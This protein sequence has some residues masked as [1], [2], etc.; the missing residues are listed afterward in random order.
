[1]V[2]E[3][4]QPSEG[5]LEFIRDTQ[6]AHNYLYELFLGVLNQIQTEYSNIFRRKPE[7]RMKTF[8][9][10]KKGFQKR[11]DETKD[12]KTYTAD[13]KDI[14]GLRLTIT[15]SDEYPFATEILVNNENLKMLG[16]LDITSRKNNGEPNKRGYSAYHY[17]LYS[18]LDKISEFLNYKLK[19][20]IDEDA[21][22]NFNNTLSTVRGF[23]SN[24]L[25]IQLIAELQI[26]TL[27]QDL[28]AV[29]EHPERYKSKV[30]SSSKAM[31][32][33]LL[34]YSKLME[35]ADDIAQLTKNRKKYDAENYLKDKIPDSPREKKILNIE[36]LSKTLSDDKLFKNSAKSLSLL[37]KC[38]ILN[39]LADN[40]IFTIEDLKLLV[41]NKDYF[42]KINISI[43]NLAIPKDKEL[44]VEV[45][46]MITMF[47]ACKKCDRDCRINTD[48]IEDTEEKYKKIGI[49]EKKLMKLLDDML[50]TIW[51][52][53]E[54]SYKVSDYGIK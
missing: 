30:G 32:E 16:N 10:I 20:D 48:Q 1:M 2:T 19:A 52:E 47:C 11:D 40:N 35:V 33:E 18:S 42:E 44:K 50:K 3:N 36:E 26:R 24:Q 45:L 14:A 23:K 49:E 4:F 41:E 17:Y 15:T 39:F 29:F 54:F 9:S 21:K 8:L 22:N 37:D 46:D 31:D 51:A 7:G 34:N 6:I 43:K 12:L 28:W 53:C 38:D 5:E 13:L 25:G 27:A